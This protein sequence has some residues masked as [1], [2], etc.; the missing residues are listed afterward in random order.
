MFSLCDL[1][2]QR[3]ETIW[4]FIKE[5]HMRIISAKFS[6]N[7]AGILGGDVIYSK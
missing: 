5:G 2:L 1:D 6:Q 4:T 3:T 7:P